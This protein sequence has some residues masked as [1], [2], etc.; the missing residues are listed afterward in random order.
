MLR[1]LRCLVPLVF[2][3]PVLRAE[4]PKASTQLQFLRTQE[5]PG[6]VGALQTLS[7]EFKP[8]S[9]VGPTIW[10]IGVSHLG[11]REYYAGLQKRLDTQNVVLFEGI[12]AQKLQEGAKADTSVG[13][14]GK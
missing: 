11:T 14:Q 1:L 7:A 5:V 9:G 10:L 13:I 2:L 6:G 12:G 4:A 3:S 8:R